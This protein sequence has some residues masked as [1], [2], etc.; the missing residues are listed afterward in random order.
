M[1]KTMRDFV[2]ISGSPT[3]MSLVYKCHSY[4]IFGPN[5]NSSLQ[6][7]YLCSVPLAAGTDR[8]VWPCTKRIYSCCLICS[9]VSCCRSRFWSGQRRCQYPRASEAALFWIRS[10]F[11]RLYFVSTSSLRII[12]H[13]RWPLVTDST[14]SIFTS[15]FG[16]SW[17]CVWP[18]A[19]IGTRKGI[20]SSA[21]CFCVT[22]RRRGTWFCRSIRSASRPSCSIRCRPNAPS[23]SAALDR[24]ANE[25]GNRQAPAT[26]VHTPALQCR[27]QAEVTRRRSVRRLLDAQCRMSIKNVKESNHGL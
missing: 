3:C 2:S 25:T 11:C 5:K 17:T 18:T 8:G 15:S 26:V 16:A 1:P 22:C 13:R 24:R 21:T 9:N 4:H 20:E 10:H 12:S 14:S 19:F 6:C 23:G 7:L 27:T